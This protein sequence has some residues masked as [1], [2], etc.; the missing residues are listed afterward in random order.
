VG[1][2]RADPAVMVAAEHN[3][4]KQAGKAG[5]LERAGPL[6]LA[7]RSSGSPACCDVCRGQMWE[8]GHSR[9]TGHLLEG[10]ADTREAWLS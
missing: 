9:G 4:F 7:R 2:Q 10:S 1:G 5:T 8:G 6:W 3:G